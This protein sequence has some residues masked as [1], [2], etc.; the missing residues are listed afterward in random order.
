MTEPIFKAKDG[1][2]KVKIPLYSIDD[3]CCVIS[4]TVM[5]CIDGGKLEPLPDL[6]IKAHYHE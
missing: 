5:F 2:P 1:N 3:I 6:S 4:E